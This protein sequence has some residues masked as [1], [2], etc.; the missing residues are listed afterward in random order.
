MKKVLGISVP[1]NVNQWIAYAGLSLVVLSTL[2]VP[3]FWPSWAIPVIGAFIG[4]YAVGDVKGFLL[5]GLVLLAAKWGLGH[6]PFV[7]RLTQDLAQNL[8]ALIAPA[9][10][11]V[12]VRSLF[13]EIKG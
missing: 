11:I 2:Q 5:A 7:G 9:M 1:R 13:N 6:V 10:L 4:I 12:A 3:A 8:T